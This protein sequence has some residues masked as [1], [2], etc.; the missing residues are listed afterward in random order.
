MRVA[1]SSL[2]NLA[3]YNMNNRQTDLFKL[4][5]QLSTGRKILTPA[6]DPVGSARVL[7]VTQQRDLNSQFIENVNFADDTLAL[8]EANLQ[9]VISTIQDIQQLAIQ[10]GNP[11]LGSAEKQMIDADIKGK[12][13]ALLALA[14][15]TD[16]SGQYMFA[17]FKG[18]TKP[19]TELAFGNVQYNGDQGQRQVQVSV[20]RNIA[21]SDAGTD[22]FFGIKTGNQTFST[23]MGQ[24]DLPRTLSLAGSSPI[25][26]DRDPAGGFVASDYRID[27][28]TGTGN[29]TVTQLSTGVT[30]APFNQA[31]LAAGINIPGT[32]LRLIALGT[33]APTT[34]TTADLKLQANAG[35]GIVSPGMVYDQPKW[36]ASVANGTNDQRFKV[37]FHSVPDPQYPND[38]TKNLVRYDILDN[39]PT[40][41]NFNRSLI[42]GY[43][44]STDTPAGAR[45]DAAPPSLTPNRF[46]RAYIPGADI[47]L[48]AL[49]GE[50]PLIP[51]WDFGAKVAVD[52]KPADGDSFQIAP[53]QK[54]DVFSTIAHFSSALTSYMQNSI[55]SAVFQNHLNTLMQ[56]LDNVLGNVLTV[57][58]SVGSRQNEIGAIRDTKTD[59]NLQ[60]TTVISKISDIDYAQAISEFS[61]TQTYLDA[62]R[63]S[64][65]STQNL[66][67]FQYIG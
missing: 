23:S 6:D 22:L 54:Q 30:S 59:L 4:Q 2:Y 46:P 63:K 33:T 20:S 38:P 62:A 13:R 61:Q 1:T 40:S 48:K 25:F 15:T 29:Y 50:T 43:N 9:Q 56:N 31:A 66:S 19:F 47:E 5:N 10:A 35:T 28:N 52:G 27:F 8:A 3:V 7:D 16:A 17:G 49:P 53:S 32:G 45:R 14:N 34:S 41:A 24:P 51:G 64:Y 39:D 57:Q 37:L 42:D 65:A 55:G 26:I 21:V 12:Y 44:Y 11:A 58:A 36:A 60:Y 18:D 67:L